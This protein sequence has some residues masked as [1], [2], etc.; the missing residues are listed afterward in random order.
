MQDNSGGMLPSSPLTPPYAAFV[1]FEALLQKA[2]REPIPAAFDKPLLIEWGIAAGN[3]SAMLTTLRS[4][5]LIDEGGRPTDLYAELRL[6]PP[7]RLAALR[8]AAELAYVGLPG[9]DRGERDENLL[10]DYFVEKRGL[11]GQMVEKA[12]R[13]YRQFMAA[14]EAPSAPSS[15]RVAPPANVSRA[16][17]P[18]MRLDRTTTVAAGP[19]PVARATRAHQRRRGPRVGVGG[20]GSENPDLTILIQVPYD[21][22]EADLTEFFRRVRRARDRS[23]RDADDRD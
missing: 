6:S 3:E 18:A 23:L 19:V 2:A 4:L 16:R 1:A 20:I 10:H 11:R 5:G 21:A 15:T 9:L 7:R 17:H 8:R 14:T 22:A 12:K 13:F